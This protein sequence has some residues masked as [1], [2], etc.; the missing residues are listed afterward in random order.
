MF[1]G[2]KKLIEKRAKFNDYLSFVFT[3]TTTVHDSNPTRLI[4]KI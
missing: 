1:W 3:S 4:S 2:D